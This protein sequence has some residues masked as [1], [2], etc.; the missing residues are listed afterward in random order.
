MKIKL[1]LAGLLMMLFFTPLTA[2][3]M[4]NY[5]TIY[6]SG[7]T[8]TNGD[9]DEPILYMTTTTLNLRAET[10]TSSTR[11]ALVQPGSRVQ[12]VNYGNGDWFAV[13][14]D[15]IYG[16]MYSQFL[17]RVP[18][19]GTPVTAGTVELVEWSEARN[20]LTVGTIATIIDVRTGL[21]YQIASFS[22][23]NHA[24]VETI[25]AEDTAIMLE[26]FGGTWSWATRPILVIVN[27][28]T[29]AA[30]INGMPHA[31][32]TRS[33][34]NMNGHVCIHFL[35]SRTHNGSIGHENDHQASV[36]EAFNAN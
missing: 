32:S 25:T 8:I 30:S 4:Q 33:G 20:I 17:T 6:Y 28:R 26:T 22:N 12:V 18:A 3:A 14:Y 15:G 11:L 5:I 36:R 27:G 35:G 7:Y 10:N 19:P 2:H 13:I 29:L 34:N 1:F 24:D 31:G 9:F 23:G 21:S 16:Y